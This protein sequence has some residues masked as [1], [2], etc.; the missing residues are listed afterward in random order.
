VTL[1]GPL[2]A[3]PLDVEVVVVGAGPV[4]TL[5][6][7]LLGCYGV[8]TV[9]VDRATEIIDYPRAIGVDDEALRVFQTAGLLP[10][11]LADT[12]QN[13]PLRFFD[14][15]GRCF[16]DVRPTT[17]E[18]GWYRRNVFVQPQAERV[19][20]AGLERFPHVRTMLGHEVTGLA[21]D[22]HAVTLTA[23]DARGAGSRLRAR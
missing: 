16:A 14:A 7:N 10:P 11:I 2:D 19:L 20:R 15:R 21:Q 12:I 5:A 9:L 13:V 17:R 22:K 23:V 1:G 8:E 18:Y 6:A 4:G 3:E